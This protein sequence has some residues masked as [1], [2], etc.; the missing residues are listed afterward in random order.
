MLTEEEAKAMPK[1]SDNQKIK[2]FGREDLLQ[3]TTPKLSITA[4]E[5]E[6]GPMSGK[7]H[8]FFVLFID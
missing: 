7:W 6:Q 5:P 3:S 8:I 1:A 4:I 2:D